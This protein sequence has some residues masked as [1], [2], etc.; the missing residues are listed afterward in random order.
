MYIFSILLLVFTFYKNPFDKINDEEF[1]EFNSSNSEALAVGGFIA[2]ENNENKTGYGLG[3]W[4]DESGG[5]WDWGNSWNTYN[6]VMIKINN[7]E[8]TD[9]ISNKTSAFLIPQ[10]DYTN[11]KYQVGNKVTFINGESRTIT[12]VKEYPDKIGEVG[13]YGIYLEVTVEG[14]GLLEVSMYGNIEDYVVTDKKGNVYPGGAF[15][16]YVSQVGLQGKIYSIFADIF[17]YNNE[18]KII[19]ITNCI[20]LAII[21]IGICLLISQKYNQLLGTVFFVVFWLSPWIIK[22]APS[23]YWVEFLWFLPMLIGLYCLINI[24]KK[25]TRIVCY[26]FIGL[27]IML[28]SLCG[29]EYITN[30][31]L[32]GIE[33]FLIEIILAMFKKD[34]KKLL[35]LLKTTFFL[36]ISSIVGFMLALTV[37]SILRG[38]GDIIT[39][40]VKIIKEDAMR[41]T[42]SIGI[43]NSALNDIALESIEASV[44]SVFI[45]YC[46]FSTDIILGIPGNL[47]NLISFMPIFICVYNFY[48]RRKTNNFVVF[49]FV[50]LLVSASWFILGKGHSYIHTSLNFVMWYFGFVQFCIYIIIK[51]FINIM[52]E[53]K[54]SMGSN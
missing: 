42:F 20:F 35:S 9:S 36:G 26:I 45:K 14:D 22:F 41:R 38:N 31:M 27:A 4:Y 46:N 47:F 23:M 16:E 13:E 49:Y 19:R 21:L 52:Y 15:K 54:E 34:R 29:Y 32:G 24:D 7:D 37:H 48:K 33:F 10:N 1:R 44:V 28:K 11:N 30:V 8:Y 2:A 53:R 17:N 50:S 3:Y 43:Q 51:Q 12:S 39:G 5:V 18:V 25:R 40:L 6:K